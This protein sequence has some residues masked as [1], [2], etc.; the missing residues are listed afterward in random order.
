[1]LTEL[2]IGASTVGTKINMGEKKI[3]YYKYRKE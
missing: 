1:M 3:F 2:R